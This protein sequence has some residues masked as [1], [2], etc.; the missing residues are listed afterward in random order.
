[1]SMRIWSRT[2]VLATVLVAVT[3]RSTPPEVHAQVVTPRSSALVSAVTSNPNLAPHLTAQEVAAGTPDSAPPI[4]GEVVGALPPGP[5][6]LSLAPRVVSSAIAALPAAQRVPQA[7]ACACAAIRAVPPSEQGR[8]V[9]AIVAAA[10][11]MAPAARLQIVSCATDAVPTMAAAITAAAG[12]APTQAELASPPT[13]PLPGS[14]IGRDVL[15]SSPQAQGCA[16][17]PCP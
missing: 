13:S 3:A 2:L 16:S 12:L 17:R 8:V 6:R 10:V 5:P 7:P 11:A 9:P 1:M 14:T 15:S 4:V